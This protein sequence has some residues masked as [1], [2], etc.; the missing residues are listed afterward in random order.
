MIDF[1]ETYRNLSDDDLLRLWA[2]RSQLLP[3]AKASLSEE[4]ARRSLAHADERDSTVPIPEQSKHDVFLK[5]CRR[6]VN[7]GLLN[8]LAFLLVTTFLGG[9][10]TNGKVENGHYYVWGVRTLSGRKVYTEVSRFAFTYSKWHFY[11]LWATL[12]FVILAA[13]AARRYEKRLEA[14][15]QLDA[16]R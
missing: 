4:L 5:V 12:P 10:A 11:S 16:K 13:S 3:V 2:E 1:R 14:S 15:H 9:D 7:I 6:I 8:I